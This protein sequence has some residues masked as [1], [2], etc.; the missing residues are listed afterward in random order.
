VVLTDPEGVEAGGL[1]E[2]DLLQQ[3]LDPF[4]RTH[5]AFRAGIGHC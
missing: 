5:A 4:L 1:R 3:V 2:H